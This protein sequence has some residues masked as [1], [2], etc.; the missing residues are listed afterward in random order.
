MSYA[1]SVTAG[2][3]S[4]NASV[5]APTLTGRDD[6]TVT[7]TL[8][9][10]DDDGLSKRRENGDGD[11]R[12]PLVNAGPDL[13]GTAGLA[14]AMST[15]FTDAGTLDTHSATVNWG[16]GTQCSPSGQ[17]TAGSPVRTPM[18]PLARHT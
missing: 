10:T 9:V 16:D 4:S 18:R 2:A 3:T 8:T 17:S 13:A 11:Q 14:V 5:M 15:S 1:W 6:A 12:G 7:L